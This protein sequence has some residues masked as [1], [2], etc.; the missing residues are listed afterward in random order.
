MSSAQG[1]TDV[2]KANTQA[3]KQVNKQAHTDVIACTLCMYIL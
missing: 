1:I 2:H 3:S